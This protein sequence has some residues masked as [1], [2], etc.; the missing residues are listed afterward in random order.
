MQKSLYTAIMHQSH[1]TWK[2]P[3]ISSYVAEKQANKKRNPNTKLGT[4]PA[5]M[6]VERGRVRSKGEGR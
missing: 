3:R 2:H 6:G 4:F 1:F 5:D